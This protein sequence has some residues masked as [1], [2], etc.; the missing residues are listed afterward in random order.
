MIGDDGFLFDD[1]IERA[2]REDIRTG[3]VTSRLVLD[4]GARGAAMLV[5]R[6]ALV[7]ACLDVAA[8]AFTRLDPE[9]RVTERVRESQRVPAGETLARIEGALRSILAAE[10]VALN[11]LQ[12]ACGI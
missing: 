8:A 12:R 10:R 1:L 6:E 9:T 7:V 11:I 4:E 5:A 2:L 3:D